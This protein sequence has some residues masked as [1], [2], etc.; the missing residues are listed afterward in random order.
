M[1]ARPY[2]PLAPYMARIQGAVRRT[3]TDAERGRRP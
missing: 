3:Y 1:P 2:P